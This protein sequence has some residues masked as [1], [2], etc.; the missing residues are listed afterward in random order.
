MMVVLV[1]SCMLYHRLSYSAKPQHPK[2]LKSSI[3]RFGMCLIDRVMLLCL[4]YPVKHF[5]CN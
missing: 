1:G 4:V 5:H 2:T 3:Q